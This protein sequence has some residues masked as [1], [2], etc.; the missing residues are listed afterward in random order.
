[1]QFYECILIFVSEICDVF[2]FKKECAFNFLEKHYEIAN[3]TIYVEGLTVK[4]EGSRKWKIY[5]KDV[6]NWFDLMG[7]SIDF[8]KDIVENGN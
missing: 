8:L 7:N 4:M 1:M 5:E 3:W 6:H 2:C